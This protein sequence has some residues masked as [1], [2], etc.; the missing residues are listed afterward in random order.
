MNARV[1]EPRRNEIRTANKRKKRKKF[2]KGSLRRAVDR[3]RIISPLPPV[4]EGVKVPA[5]KKRKKERKRV[6]STLWTLWPTIVKS[7]NDFGTRNFR[8]T[9][10]RGNILCS[11]RNPRTYLCSRSPWII[12]NE[13][14][15]PDELVKSDIVNTPWCLSELLCLP[16]SGKQRRAG[17]LGLVKRA[18]HRDIKQLVKR[19]WSQRSRRPVQIYE[20]PSEGSR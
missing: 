19:E 17:L 2:L 20:V 10:D 3:F 18:K 9:A 14:G 8:S 12:V 13:R 15:R 16:L 7:T 11:R 5:K 6:E 4:A 1:A